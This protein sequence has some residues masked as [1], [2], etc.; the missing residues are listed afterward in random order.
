MVDD[1]VR[2]R[3][4]VVEYNEQKWSGVMTA[5]HVRAR[6]CSVGAG[7]RAFNIIVQGVLAVIPGKEG[8]KIGA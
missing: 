5:R 3:G 8:A 4:L 2:S 7:R 1:P 6:G